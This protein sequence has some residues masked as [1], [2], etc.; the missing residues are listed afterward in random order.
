MG[1]VDPASVRAVIFDFGGTLGFDMPTYQEGYTTLLAAAGLPVRRAGISRRQRRGPTPIARR[2]P[3]DRDSWLEWRP[4]YKPGHPPPS[5]G[6][7]M[8]SPTHVRPGRRAAQVLLP[9]R[10]AIP[11]LTLS[12]EP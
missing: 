7:G 10:I 3:R 8:R 2:P 12:C 11:R 6:A 5:R 1:I 9:A 4:Y